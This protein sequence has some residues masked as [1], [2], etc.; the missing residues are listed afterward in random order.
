[1]PRLL[2]AALL[3]CGLASG[4]QAESL[5]EHQAAYLKA[6]H[7]VIDMVD[8]KTVDADQVSALVL[9][10]E[11]HAQPLALAYAAKFPTGKPVIDIII[12]QVVTVDAKGAVTGFGPMQDIPYEVIEKRWHD[13]GYFKEDG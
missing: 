12:A 4:V 13:L 7:A 1:M 9:T 8:A 3:A 2:A 5:T 10:M 11:R 6:G